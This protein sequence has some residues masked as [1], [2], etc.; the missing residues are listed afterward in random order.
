MYLK[1]ALGYFI[2]TIGITLY[3]FVN[4][5]LFYL[6]LMATTAS[7]FAALDAGKIP[8]KTPTTKQIITVLTKR[9]MEIYTGKLSGPDNIKVKI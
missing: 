4:K 6:L 5:T 2:N 7:I 1:I 9:G 3:L 8:A